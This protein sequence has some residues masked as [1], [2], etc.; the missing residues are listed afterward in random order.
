MALKRKKKKVTKKMQKGSIGNFFVFGV[1]GLLLVVGVMAIGGLP[2]QTGPTSGQE[3]EVITPTP[4]TAY[5]NLQLKT[6]GYVTIAPTPTP[7][8]GSICTSAVNSEPSI[9]V[10][11]Q[12]AAGQ[13]VSSTGQVIVWVNDEGAPFIA[14]GEEVDPTTGAVT[15][16]G[17]RAAKAGDG[18]LFE[19][20]LYIAPATVEAG[21]QPHFPD[22][23]K[24]QF[25]NTGLLGN[26]TNG[27]AYDPLPAGSPPVGGPNPNGFGFNQYV[28]E[29][30]WNVS[31]LG[32]TTGTYQ[33]EFLI[34]DGDRDRAAGCV[35]ITIQ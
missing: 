19:P 34:H 15:T 22:F 4:G 17:D 5:N 28:A 7:A 24:G 27:P 35:T 30:I 21:G 9:I 8:E 26:V 29:Y 10:A 32:L 18:Y 23:I 16:I 11:Y 31:N 13:T 1:L 14:P 25:N 2:S 33:A 6:F 20:A 3:V 12:P